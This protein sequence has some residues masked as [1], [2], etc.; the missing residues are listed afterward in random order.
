MAAHSGVDGGSS[1][2]SGLE[3]TPLVGADLGLGEARQKPESGSA[4]KLWV[5]M[6][7]HGTMRS[8]KTNPP[9]KQFHVECLIHNCKCRF[10][11]ENKRFT[12][13]CMGH[14]QQ[15][16]G[17]SRELW[18]EISASPHR[19]QKLLTHGSSPEDGFSRS[20]GRKRRAGEHVEQPEAKVLQV[21]KKRSTA[22]RNLIQSYVRKVVVAA[23]VGLDRQLWTGLRALLAAHVWQG[24]WV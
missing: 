8:T 11:W 12:N 22:L 18:E 20:I 5:G 16:H 14:L 21:V 2:V 3:A 15:E 10:F 9:G 17:I 4:S 7:Q 24:V 6:R 19:L 23:N 13:C 1:S